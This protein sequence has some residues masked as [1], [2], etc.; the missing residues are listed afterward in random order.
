MRFSYLV[1]HDYGYRL[2]VDDLPSATVL[3]GQT[4]YEW[5]VPLGYIPEASELDTDSEWSQQK[6]FKPVAIYN[7]LEIKVKVHPTIKSNL[8][9]STT[10]PNTINVKVPTDLSKYLSDKGLKVPDNFTVDLPS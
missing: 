2:F 9:G 3:E 7:H 5:T 4:H 8:L 1:E 10:E 6:L